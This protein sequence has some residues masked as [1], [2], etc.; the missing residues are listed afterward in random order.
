[1]FEG[2]S[3]PYRVPSKGKVD[4]KEFPTKAKQKTGSEDRLH[5]QLQAAVEALDNLQRVFFANNSYS[6]LLIFQAMDA[7]GKDSTIR[8]VM[9]GVDP[10]GCQVFSFKQPSTE[11][12]DHDFLWRCARCLPERGRIGIFNRSYYEETLVVR[13]H[14]E[15][16]AQQRLPKLKNPDTL[17]EQRFESI[18]NFEEHLARNGTIV[19]KFWLNVSKEEQRRRFLARLAEPSKHWKFAVGDVAE[20]S[21]WKDYMKAYQKA[22]TATSRPWAPWYA[23]PAD[24]KDFMQ[25]QVAQIVVETLRS[26]KLKFPKPEQEAKAEFAAIQQRLSAETE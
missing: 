16:L 10:T 22:L 24:H 19:L 3:S 21:H 5:G 11:E 13:V 17:W 6:L 9:R 8:A 7:A 15:F 20:R 14:P 23:I 18:R 25:L 12:L 2:V 4:W 26:L 1:M